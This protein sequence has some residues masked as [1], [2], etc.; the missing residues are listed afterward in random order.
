MLQLAIKGMRGR[1]KDTR[2]LA[3]VIALSFLF[4]T[5]GT[6]LLSSFTETQE[7]QRQSLYGS[8][9]LLYGGEEENVLTALD[10]VPL[11][12][13]MTEVTIA[14]FD[15]SCGTV[16][17]WNEELY[18][19]NGIT[20]SEGRMPQNPGE[21]VLEK[22]Q[23]GQFD[24]EIG[25]GSKI[26]LKFQVTQ[27]SLRQQ[28][29]G[30]D[31]ISIRGKEYPAA[32]IAATFGYGADEAYIQNLLRNLWTEELWNLTSGEFNDQGEENQRYWFPESMRMEIDQMPD[33]TYLALIDGFINGMGE[34]SPADIWFMRQL[35]SDSIGYVLR[36]IYT[37]S[38]DG[39]VDWKLNTTFSYT[40]AK[41]EDSIEYAE[42]SDAILVRDAGVS[43]QDLYLWLNCEVVGIIETVSDRWDVGELS[44][45]NCY[46]TQDSLQAVL[47]KTQELNGRTDETRLYFDYGQEIDTLRFYSGADSASEFYQLLSR[48][49]FSSL[50]RI[51]EDEFNKQ[52]SA[53]TK[54]EN[55]GYAM[56]ESDYAWARS[57]LEKQGI[58]E[59]IRSL[60]WPGEYD[61]YRL[62][63]LQPGE[64]GVRY[65]VVCWA[66]RPILRVELE[67]R[68]TLEFP[69]QDAIVVI[70]GEIVYVEINGQRLVHERPAEG[71]RVNFQELLYGA[72]VNGTQQAMKQMPGLEDAYTYN[73]SWV[74][75]NRY[76]FPMEGGLTES[77][78]ITIIGV[79]MAVTV[80]A[81]FQIFFTQLRRRTRKL[82]LL[83]SVGATNGQIMELLG[84]E[85]L[86]LLSVGLI[87]GDLL[88][89]G[90]AA[91]VVHS[92]EGTMLY[93]DWPLLLAG[94]VCGILA[95]VT[96]M[97]IPSVRS[98][99]T[100]LVGRMEGKPRRHVKIREMKMQTWKR[101]CLRDLRSN[102][103]R[104][105]GTGALCVFLVAMEL[106]C[107]FLGNASFDTYRQT[108]EW[109]DKPDYTVSMNLAGSRRMIAGIDEALAVVEE[110]ERVDFYRVARNAFVWSDGLEQSPVL[111][112]LKE[113]GGSKFFGRSNATAGVLSLP[114]GILEQEAYKTDVYGIDYDT[115]LFRRL[116]AAI[117]VGAIDPEAYTQGKQ[118]IVLCPV[119]CELSGE[120][121]DNLDDRSMGAFLESSKTMALSLNAAQGESWSRDTSLKL[122]QSLVIGLDKPRIG[123]KEV[124]YSLE[125]NNPTVGAIIYYFPGQ[126]VWPFADDPKSFTVIGSSQMLGKILPDGYVTKEPSEMTNLQ[127]SID[128]L[129]SDRLGE[130]HYS[131]YA[132]EDST[133]DTTLSPLFQVS[134]SMSMTLGNFRDSNQA[135][136]DKAL[137]SCL[138]I[139]ALAVAATIIVWMILNNTLASAQEQSRKRTGILQALGITQEE[140]YRAQS[141]QAVG[142]WLVSVAAANLLLV[143]LVLILGA[144]ERAGQNLNLMALAMTI[145]REDLQAY[146][147]WLHGMACLL[148]LPVLLIFHHRAA[149]IPLAYSPIENI[150]S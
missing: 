131:F 147:W 30:T 47:D 114:K 17:V 94:Q 46:I 74:K 101:I 91:A 52:L 57:E 136:H 32:E 77:M 81:V 109:A 16:G 2:V 21:I 38:Q 4:L 13:G 37:G 87:L 25:V 126:G 128:W 95:V 123:E 90:L 142:Y 84:L 56:E 117:T 76:G 66:Y 50:E 3:L 62:E 107:V 29:R 146:P 89:F 79:L 73:N 88:G 92:L 8:W 134:R 35:L 48:Q 44:L 22:G 93:I 85:C 133:P 41:T 72:S 45:P 106:A 69:A 137:A 138:L 149:K 80:C 10:R 70:P 103:G 24:Q 143:V 33:E 148:E 14:G 64:D 71:V 141:I 68:E 34:G 53:F 31:P 104:T 42:D 100:P 58:T 6:I 140:W 19:L 111:T 9:Q 59:N 130:A 28:N 39:L 40:Y 11:D 55:R 26:Q 118:A 127:T 150:R 36:V 108:V 119:Y 65:P 60:Q 139:G 67:N 112:A 82:T 20:L 12:T 132:T 5:T 122:G 75:I 116:E 49:E 61:C 124:V 23:L 105:L 83:K 18:A 63:I 129:G 97:M 110:V 27:K 96:G 54:I 86:V 135:V 43:Q 145:L 7:R 102:P 99:R 120:A 115:D 98:A 113:A 121:G 125:W 1:K 144:V 15:N 51:D 78:G